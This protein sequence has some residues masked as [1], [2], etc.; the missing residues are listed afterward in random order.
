M[1]RAMTL[2]ASNPICQAFMLNDIHGFSI[3]CLFLLGS[4]GFKLLRKCGRL[5][6][7]VARPRQ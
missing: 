5:L 6:A 4:D 2:C 1:R 3:V 7:Q